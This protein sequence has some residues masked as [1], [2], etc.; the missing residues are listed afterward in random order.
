[1]T[2]PLEVLPFEEYMLRDDRP[3]YP[4]N[5]FARL[6]FS[7]PLERD[8][9]EMAFQTALS[10]HPL[11]R[12]IVRPAA[13]GRLEWV[14][15][16]PGP[17]P[18]VWCRGPCDGPFPPTGGI[19]LTAESGLKGWVVEDGSRAVLV[20]QFHHACCDGVG[21]LQVVEDFLLAYSSALPGPPGRNGLQRLEPHLLPGREAFGL[22]P[23][24]GSR[25]LPAQA[26]GLLGLR[27]LLT[28]HPI[29][30]LAHEPTPFDPLPPGY[31]AVMTR[32]LPPAELRALKQL[33][34]RDGVTVNQRL[35][36]DLFV[37]VDDFQARYQPHAAEGWLRFSVPI[38]LREAKDRRLP[39]ANVVSMVFLDRRRAQIADPDRLL[40]S[41][42]HDLELSRR[43]RL[44]LT[45][46]WSISF[47]RAL[48]GGL[49]HMTMGERCV[50]TCVISNLG[51]VLRR[52]PLERQQGR[53]VAGNVV[54]E[55]MDILAP[56]RPGTAAAF[57]IFCY[58]DALCVSMHYDPRRLAR[59]QATDLLDSF[60]RRVRA[61][62][63]G[64]AGGSGV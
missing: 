38:N 62:L 64:Q 59:E 37:A 63:A 24:N 43:L 48:P 21:L 46:M 39:A 36:R 18:L 27:Q 1:M 13:H 20:L 58:A 44:G 32:Q 12:A 45:F 57:L 5:T 8:A 28:R 35:I 55:D 10:R 53:I 33:A 54:L 4:M 61:P 2:L 25:A 23:Q 15:A 31:P 22:T 56:L 49:D 19:D 29:P 3:G 40:A 51:T 6:R 16:D 26:T 42:H 9:A 60:L 41:I 50:A 52:T 7:G 47:F 17:P 34:V 11:L 14:A 30:L